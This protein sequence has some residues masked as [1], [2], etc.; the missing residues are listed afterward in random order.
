[1]AVFLGIQGARSSPMDLFRGY[2][3]FAKKLSSPAKNSSPTKVT[4]QA[5]EQPISSVT[6]FRSSNAQVV[7]NLTLNLSVSER[8]PFLL[9]LILSQAGT[10]QININGL[11]S[12]IDTE[13]LRVSG[14]GNARLV[15][16]GCSID[17]SIPRSH[18]NYAESAKVR[19]AKEQ[20][21][22][23]EFE[24]T[25]REEDIRLSSRQNDSPNG[26][27][28][29]ISV[30]KKLAAVKI[31]RKLEVRICE[32]EIFVDSN[33]QTLIGEARANANITVVA[34]RLAVFN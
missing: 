33:H 13:S 7:R 20:I 28:P 30:S 11:S 8:Y 17:S 3:P 21:R 23:L 9:V 2:S 31:I 32:L 18:D 16:V 4:L 1:M 26:G 15:S 25:I 10:N 24:K 14:L 5:S 22:E 6:V 12:S 34:I 29:S 19:E 27:S